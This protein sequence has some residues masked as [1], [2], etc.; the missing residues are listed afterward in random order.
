VIKNAKDYHSS[1]NSSDVPTLKAGHSIWAQ[2]LI[3]VADVGAA[4]GD[5]LSLIISK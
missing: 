3:L 2:V 4:K 1:F 5:A